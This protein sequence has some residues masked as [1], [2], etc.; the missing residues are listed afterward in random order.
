MTLG[1]ACKKPR[2]NALCLF[3]PTAIEY[4]SRLGKFSS[5]KTTSSET[6][7]HLESCEAGEVQLVQEDCFDVLFSTASVCMQ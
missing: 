4:F 2:N 5:C 6:K 3:D 1:N 7:I